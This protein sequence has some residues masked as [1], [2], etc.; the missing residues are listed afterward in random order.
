MMKSYTTTTTALTA[1]TTTQNGAVDWNHIDWKSL[2]LSRL[3]LRQGGGDGG[4]SSGRL[5]RERE[6]GIGEDLESSR[7]HWLF[8]GG[9]GGYWSAP[10]PTPSPAAADT[11]ASSTAPELLPLSVHEAAKHLRFM[12]RR[13]MAL[14]NDNNVVEDWRFLALVFDRFLLFVFVAVTLGKFKY[15]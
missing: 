14:A 3:N 9:G 5:G 15:R 8:G 10:S 1:S 4:S 12:A 13:E 6:T 11:T 2:S 7:T